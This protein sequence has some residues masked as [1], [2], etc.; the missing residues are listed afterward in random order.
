MLT[1]HDIGRPLMSLSFLHRQL[2]N[3]STRTRSKPTLRT[4]TSS[5]HGRSSTEGRFTRTWRSVKTRFCIN[6]WVHI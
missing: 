4:T 6:L 2:S 3:R 1:R 5:S